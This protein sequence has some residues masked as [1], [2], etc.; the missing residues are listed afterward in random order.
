MSFIDNSQ[1]QYNISQVTRQGHFIKHKN[2]RPFQIEKKKKNLNRK[3]KS[4]MKR[5]EIIV[6][7]GEMLVTSIF[8][9]FTV[10]YSLSTKEILI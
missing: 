7:K 4:S 5:A 6:G 10:F 2:C 1:F 3:L 8:S 9:F